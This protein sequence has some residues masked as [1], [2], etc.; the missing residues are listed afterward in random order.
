M[1]ASRALVIG[2]G[3]SYHSVANFDWGSFDGLVVST[4]FY[5]HR[6]GAVVTI[7]PRRFEEKERHAIG[8][9]RLVVALSHWGNEIGLKRFVPRRFH[10]DVEWAWCTHPVL[11]SGVY[12]IEWAAQQ[13]CKEIY[14][15]GVD[16]TPGYHKRLDTQRSLL[17]R[18]LSALEAKGVRVYK[19]SP[20]STLPVPVRDPAEHLPEG[21][22]RPGPA[23]PR[24][25]VVAPLRSRPSPA[26][27]VALRRLGRQR[28]VA[29]PERRVLLRPRNGKPRIVYVSDLPRS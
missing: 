13:G 27:N 29:V 28:P 8:K 1:S 23:P 4:H 3:P 9:A 26:P 2:D 19:R 12:A 21:A 7:D 14:T 22:L 20:A 11:T 15:M 5:R 25:P 10:K 18:T 24:G 17:A 16:L 6:A